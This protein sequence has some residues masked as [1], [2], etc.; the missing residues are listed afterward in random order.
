MTNEEKNKKIEEG[1]ILLWRCMLTEDRRKRMA[2]GE[3]IIKIFDDVSDSYNNLCKTI[4]DLIDKLSV[5]AHTISIQNEQ[6]NYIQN[7]ISQKK[8]KNKRR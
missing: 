1:T 6:I 8:K 7:E 5:A 3:E 2:Y 4:N